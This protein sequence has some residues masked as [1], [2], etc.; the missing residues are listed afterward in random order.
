MSTYPLDLPLT[1]GRVILTAVGNILLRFF[2]D[3]VKARLLKNSILFGAAAA[4][5]R[6]E[7]HIKLTGP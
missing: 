2:P 3:V 6:S 1:C 7:D 5:K 4:G